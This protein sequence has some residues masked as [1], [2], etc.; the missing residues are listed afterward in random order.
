MRT[1]TWLQATWL[2]VAAG[3]IA[4]AVLGYAAVVPTAL[5]Y[6]AI[7]SRTCL[8]AAC[9]P[10]TAAAVAG[11]ALGCLAALVIA[12]FAIWFA[13]RPRAWNALV[14]VV[15]VAMLPIALAV[16][17]FGLR[18]L[19][20]G[21]A[22][23][24]EAMQFAYAVDAVV[25]GSIVE[26]TGLPLIDQP[27]VLGP[28]VD[29]TVCPTNSGAFAAMVRMRFTGSSGADDGIRSAI[30]R[31]IGTSTTRVMAGLADVALTATWEQAQDEWVLTVTS[32]CQPI[33]KG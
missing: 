2:R 10:A 27:G 19:S 9:D 20:D 5:L 12:V 14:V 4:L 1:P 15:A 17:V 3:V 16:Q 22:V 24:G 33:P 29:V 26:A 30:E 6:L 18:T 7:D 13:I 28:E 32:A 23:G 11:G 21:R 25:E 8:G 31:G